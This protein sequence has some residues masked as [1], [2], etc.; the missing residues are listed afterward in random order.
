MSLYI[1]WANGKLQN[2]RQYMAYC[3][4]LKIIYRFGIVEEKRLIDII[5]TFRRFP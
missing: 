3:Y 1:N 2:E 4:M 5:R